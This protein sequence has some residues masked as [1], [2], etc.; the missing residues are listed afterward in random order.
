MNAKKQSL[1]PLKTLPTFI[2]VAKHLSFSKAAGELYVTHSAVSQSIRVLEAFLGVKLFDRGPNKQ[3][4]L[5]E[6]GKQY[7]PE[8][9]GAIDTIVGATQRQLG[10]SKDN[11]LTVNVITTLTMR[12]LIPRLP[13]FQT[14]YPD[15]DLRLSTLGREVDFTRDNIDLGI[16]YGHEDDW[17][18]LY[19]KKLFDDQLVLVAHPKIIPKSYQLKN[20]INQFKS[21]YVDYEYRKYDWKQWCQQMGIREP[22]KSNRIYFQN[23]SLALQA[24]ASGVG[25]IVTHKPFIIDDV[26]SGQLQLLSDTVLS[27][28][29]GYYVICPKEKFE[30]QKV[31]EFCNWLAK[32][33]KKI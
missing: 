25:I 32:E 15:I 23:S 9:N 24:A 14:D 33:A 3:V 22:K 31:S 19:S 13:S 21:I 30:L 6:Q 8:I 26:R 17:P 29:K 18:Q 16:V 12:W 4:T 2:A 28:S 5:T 7:F 27:L 1:P 10:I 11:R 20:L